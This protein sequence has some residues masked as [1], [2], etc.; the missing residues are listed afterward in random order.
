MSSLH[1]YTGLFLLSCLY[2]LL[3]EWSGKAYEPDYTWLTVTIGV[4][5]T[6]AGVA[7]RLWLGPLPFAGPAELVWWTWR[8]WACSFVASGTPIILWQLWQAR[9]RLAEVI[10]YATKRGDRGEL[11]PAALAEKQ[12]SGEAGDGSGRRGDRSTAD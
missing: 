9:R 11:Y 8:L 10:D 5:Y 2:A 3:L 6:G 7:L 1:L 12:R 4:S